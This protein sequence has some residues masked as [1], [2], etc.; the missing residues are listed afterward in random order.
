MTLNELR[1]LTADDLEKIGRALRDRSRHLYSTALQME[2]GNEPAATDTVVG[3]YH[4]LSKEYGELADKF[5]CYDRRHNDS[6]QKD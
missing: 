3:I 5:P 1:S 6:R 2:L 4:K